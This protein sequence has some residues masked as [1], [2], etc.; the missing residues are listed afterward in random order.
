[1]GCP[2]FKGDWDEQYIMCLYMQ[3]VLISVYSTVVYR[4]PLPSSN[5][6][7]QER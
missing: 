6:L 4:S 1:M 5:I 3:G 2:K 7:N